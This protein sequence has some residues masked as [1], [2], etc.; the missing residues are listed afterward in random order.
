[1]STPL[2]PT[3]ML[4]FALASLKQLASRQGPAYLR[5]LSRVITRHPD[6]LW[7]AFALAAKGYHLR[8][9]T[10]QVT[11]VDNFKHSLADKIDHL[12]EDI[13]RRAHDG[14]TRLKAYVRGL[15]AQVRREYATIH[16]DFRHDVDD[17]LNTFMSALDASLQE[18]HF[19]RSMR[20][21]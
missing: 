11:A 17:A 20:M 12:Q 15:V 14:H 19:P 5:F 6:M 7:E 13:A 18:L 4:R 3:E 2:H 1:M 10:E 21:L 9:I 16:H 8:K